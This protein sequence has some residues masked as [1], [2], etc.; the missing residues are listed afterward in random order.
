[1]LFPAIVIFAAFV[2]Y[3]FCC[4]CLNRNNNTS[5]NRSHQDTTYVFQVATPRAQAP[6]RQPQAPP[7]AVETT[8]LDEETINSFPSMIIGE[9]GRMIKQHDN[10]CSICLSEYNP[11][12]KLKILPLCL[13]R[14]HSDCIDQW[15][16]CNGACPI[17]R[18][19]PPD[20]LIS[21]L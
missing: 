21:S 7:Q 12:E 11:K 4:C 15:L 2:C 14:F 19:L 9:S 8:G 10:T 16:R 6:P 5:N 18:I 13:H 20:I 3:A 17:C 1:M